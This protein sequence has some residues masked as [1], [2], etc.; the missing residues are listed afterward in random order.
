AVINTKANQTD[1]NATN[2]TVAQNKA[3]SD[4][5]I[6]LTNQR[7]D[8]T[9]VVVNDTVNRVTTVETTVTKQG[10]L[11][12]TVMSANA[13]SAKTGTTTLGNGSNNNGTTG[14]TLVGNNTSTTANNGTALG[15]GAATGGVGSVAVGYDAKAPADNSVA[16]GA[17]SLANRP[18]TVSVGSA[19]AER[20]ITNVAA[21]TQG[22][23]AVNVNQLNALSKDMGYRLNNLDKNLSGG[24]AG[25]VAISMMPTLSEGR[26]VTGGAGFYNGESAVSLGLTGGFGK[27]S[28]KVGAAWASNGDSSV[29]G[30]IGYR[31]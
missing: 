17:N 1:L 31:W 10:Q 7:I 15:N 19:G 27:V 24:I 4:N 30:G 8:R 23:D 21:G 9:N 18:D 5:Q 20:Q 22:T 25:A 11:I 26:M 13:N 6:A 16:L 14:S 29:G 12:D 3:T 2:A 28:Y